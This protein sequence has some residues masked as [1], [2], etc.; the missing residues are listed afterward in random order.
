MNLSA[1]HL[2]EVIMGQDAESAFYT[3]FDLE[4][5]G[6]FIRTE[7]CFPGNSLYEEALCM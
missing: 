4:L 6:R 2:V 3:E 1:M 7:W 5:G